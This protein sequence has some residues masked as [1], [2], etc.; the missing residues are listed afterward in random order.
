M[1]D[2]VLVIGAGIA[3]IQ[4][5]LDLAKS[6]SKVVL[7]ERGPAI[8]GIMAA[9]DKNFPTLD[10]SICIEAPKMREV[11]EHDNIE[12]LTLAEVVSVEGEAGDF[13]V[14]IRAQ[15]GFVTDECT[16]CDDCVPVCPH[17]TI[18]KS[19]IELGTDV[20]GTPVIAAEVGGLAFL[21]KDGLTGYHVPGDDP[22]ALCTRLVALIT[23]RELQAKMGAQAADYAKNYSWRKIAPQI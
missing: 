2:S 15:P 8:G 18:R 9:L 20:V 17:Q 11:V 7:V 12:V 23:N 4:A 5:A 10:C 21:V 19:G 14:R 6:G 22:E 16:R 3:G 13:R 1:S